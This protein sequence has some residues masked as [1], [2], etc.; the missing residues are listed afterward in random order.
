M[1][2]LRAVGILLETGLASKCPELSLKNS[3]LL[4]YSEGSDLLARVGITSL[5]MEL[6]GETT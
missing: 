2:R 6:N 5:L 4:I 3:L 1:E